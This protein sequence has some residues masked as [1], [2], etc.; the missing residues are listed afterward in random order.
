MVIKD[1]FISQ[2]LSRVEDNSLIDPLFLFTTYMQIYAFDYKKMVSQIAGDR[3]A[4]NCH[5]Y[6]SLIKTVWLTGLIVNESTIPQ[7]YQWM[8][9]HLQKATPYLVLISHVA[10]TSLAIATDTKNAI[11]QLILFA[12]IGLTNQNAT[13]A[14]VVH[15]TVTIPLFSIHI[16]YSQGAKRAAAIITIIGSTIVHNPPLRRKLYQYTPPYLHRPALLFGIGPDK[17]T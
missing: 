3:F 6:I 15:N 9:T 5:P 13:L 12:V 1:F 10:M 7:K 8:K 4:L 14:Q 17:V 16:Y 11:L 2:K